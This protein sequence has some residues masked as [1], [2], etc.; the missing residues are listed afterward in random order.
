MFLAVEYGWGG[1]LTSLIVARSGSCFGRRGSMSSTPSGVLSTSEFDDNEGG[2]VTS[3]P[4]T[5]GSGWGQWLVW[6]R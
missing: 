4:W 6:K 3:S 2:C 1:L 5:D